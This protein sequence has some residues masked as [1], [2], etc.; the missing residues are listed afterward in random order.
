VRKVETVTRSHRS[1]RSSSGCDARGAPAGHRCRK[2]WVYTRCRQ[3]RLPLARWADQGRP[4]MQ[5]KLVPFDDETWRLDLL[6]R[7][8]MQDF[9]SG[10]L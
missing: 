6:K 8:R 4:L 2:S 10:R 9:Q 5:G 1:A 7:D 3:R